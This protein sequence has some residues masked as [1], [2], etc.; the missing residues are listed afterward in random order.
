MHL[1][2]SSTS[3]AGKRIAFSYP[4]KDSLGQIF[5]RVAE[6][7]RKNRPECFPTLVKLNGYHTLALSNHATPRIHLLHKR[8]FSWLYESVTNDIYQ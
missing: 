6:N 2:S 3:R 1:N 4:D 5:S 8:S 7:R